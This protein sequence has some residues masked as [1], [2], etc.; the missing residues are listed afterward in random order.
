MRELTYKYIDSKMG[1]TRSPKQYQIL[2]NK[3]YSVIY[4]KDILQYASFYC[5]LTKE[6]KKYDEAINNNLHRES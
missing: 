4:S 6:L 3:D 5:N 1:V 2:V